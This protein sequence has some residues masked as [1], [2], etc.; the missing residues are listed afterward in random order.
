M[1]RWRRSRAATLFVSVPRSARE[2]AAVLR[3]EIERHNFQYYALDQPLISMPRMT[4]FFERLQ[5]L[6]REHPEL[7]T[8]DSPT[9]RVGTAPVSEFG[10]IA[11]RVAMLSLGNAFSEDEV[12]PSIDACAKASAKR[13]SNT[14]RSPSSTGSRSA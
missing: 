6:E 7:V 12:P 1:P 9:Q 11:H 14:R 5:A 3:E 4:R 10:Q 2:R 13:R 8:A